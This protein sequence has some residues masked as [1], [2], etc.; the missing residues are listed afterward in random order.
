MFCPNTL[1][2]IMIIAAT[3]NHRG[4]MSPETWWLAA[5]WPAAAAGLRCYQCSDYYEPSCG[6]FGQGVEHDCHA[7]SYCMKQVSTVGGAKVQVHGCGN[8]FFSEEY[9]QLNYCN[10]Q[11]TNTWQRPLRPTV[12]LMAT[13]ATKLGG[14][15]R[16]AAAT[17]TCEWRLGRILLRSYLVSWLVFRCNSSLCLKVPGI[18]ATIVVVSILT[19]LVHLF[20]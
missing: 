17:R 1:F 10:Y 3:I 14:Q 6:Q 18:T 15:R 4:D 12:R 13:V 7:S 5:L 8:F 19:K 9:G 20:L 16:S 2:S 11:L